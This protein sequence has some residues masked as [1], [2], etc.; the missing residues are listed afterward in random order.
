MSNKTEFTH[1]EA[2]D[3]LKLSPQ[4]LY[5]SR[6]AGKGPKCSKKTLNG[7]GAGPTTRLIYKKSDLD[8]WDAARKAKKEK[9]S[10]S[11]SARKANGVS[12]P[13]ERGKA[14]RKTELKAA[15]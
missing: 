14:S 7:G 12:K 11:S 8:A 2:A 15:A 10:K 5:Q 1:K 6:H 3:Y 9:L 4:Y 13:K